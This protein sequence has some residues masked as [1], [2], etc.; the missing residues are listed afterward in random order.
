MAGPAVAALLFILDESFEANRWHSLVGNLDGVTLDE[1]TWLPPGGS[2]SIRDM[3][4]H[5][6]VCKLMYENHAFGD[7]SLT[8]DS[9]EP[10][11]AI[12]AE[13]ASALDWLR[14]THARLRG[15]IAALNDAELAV[16]RR[17]NWGE[18]YETRWLVTTMIQHDV[19]HAG[20]INHLRS[21]RDDDRWAHV[22]EGL[23]G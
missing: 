12:I 13:P 11:T 18:L 23:S 21:P 17:A 9:V 10:D 16:P 7:G 2:R 14:V 4:H 6:G 5:V 15:S 20:E 22:R 19:Y 3:V 1:W 8:W